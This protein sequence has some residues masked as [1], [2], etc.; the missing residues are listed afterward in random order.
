M[1]DLQAANDP[2]YD[3]SNFAQLIDYAKD[4]ATGISDNHR[5]YVDCNLPELKLRK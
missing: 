5:S 4:P 1:V 2:R 3:Q